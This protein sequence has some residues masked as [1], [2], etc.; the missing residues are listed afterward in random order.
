MPASASGARRRP[1]SKKRSSAPVAVRKSRPVPVLL[2]RSGTDS[3]RSKE[4]SLVHLGA[5]TRLSLMLTPKAEGSLGSQTREVLSTMTTILAKQPRRM[6]VTSQT[7]FLREPGDEPKCK[8]LL[9]AHYGK[10]RPITN[11]VFQPPANGAALAVEAWAIGGK[12]VQ[13][14]RFGTDA[15]SVNYD[16]IRWVSCAA[17]NPFTAQRGAYP[18]TLD[19]LRRLHRALARARFVLEIVVR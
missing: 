18:Q 5:S 1:T 13:I 19:A 11:F 17:S 15:I 6:V 12:S 4:S 3:V 7:I 9:S 10:R 2:S 16:G 14:E 8:R